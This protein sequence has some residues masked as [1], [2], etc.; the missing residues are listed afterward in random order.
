MFAWHTK[1]F[2]SRAALS[3][4]SSSIFVLILCIVRC[5]VKKIY[6]NI[7]ISFCK[8]L[9]RRAV[10]RVKTLAGAC[11]KV[12]VF[13]KSGSQTISRANECAASNMPVGHNVL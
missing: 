2:I 11:G 4:L 6:K 13:D 5:L 7:N 3:L 10:G 9:L 1:H 12:E 8:Y